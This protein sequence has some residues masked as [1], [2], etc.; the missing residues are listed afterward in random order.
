[1]CVASV[2]MSVLEFVTYKRSQVP[3]RCER[4]CSVAVRL[5]VLVR[6]CVCVCLAVLVYVRL[7]AC[8]PQSVCGFLRGAVCLIVG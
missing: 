4:E 8:E 2:F 7:C 5:G 3:C 1:M 6:A